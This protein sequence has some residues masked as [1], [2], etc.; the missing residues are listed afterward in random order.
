M[1]AVTL[2]AVTENVAEVEPCGTVTDERTFATEEFE[3]ESD[4]TAPPEPAGPER[5]TVPVADCPLT[6]V[7]GLTDVPMSLGGG[8]LMVKPNVSLTPRYAAINV[9]GVGVVTL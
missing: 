4:T 6:I 5:L 9:T 3:L 2:P 1:L 8:G 7:S